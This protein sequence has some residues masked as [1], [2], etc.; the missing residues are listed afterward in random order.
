M[1]GNT[2]PPD[3]G[4]FPIHE[5]CGTNLAPTS[6]PCVTELCE[7]AIAA[8]CKIYP[9]VTE[10]FDSAMAASCKALAL[11]K[12]SVLRRGERRRAAD[13]VTHDIRTHDRVREHRRRRRPGTDRLRARALPFGGA[14]ALCARVSHLVGS[15]QARKWLSH[16]SGAGCNSDQLLSP[17]LSTTHGPNTAN[18]APKWADIGHL[19]PASA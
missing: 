8:S 19:C 13:V 18:I 9:C 12:A 7:S 17:I 14:G 10:L 16:R 1:D 4:P 11:S 2:L 15:A 6:N 5:V 3:G